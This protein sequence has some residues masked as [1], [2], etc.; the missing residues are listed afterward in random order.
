MSEWDIRK[1]KVVV[2]ICVLAYNHG[3]YIEE[4]LRSL[5][6]QE[7]DFP[8][9]ICIGEDES[10]DET[11]EICQKYASENPDKIRLFLRSRDDV[12][13]INGKATGQY[14][15]MKTLKACRG[16]YIAVCEADDYWSDA[17]KLQVQVSS[18]EQNPDAALCFCNI[19]V[20]Y[21]DG[22]EGHPGYGTLGEQAQS[23]QVG[24]FV[25]PPEKTDILRLA[26]G[27]FIHTPGVL[28][29]NWFLTEPYPEFMF[30]LNLVIG[31]FICAPPVSGTLSS[32]ISSYR[33]I[34]RIRAGCGRT[35]LLRC[36]WP[37]RFVLDAGWCN[38]ASSGTRLCKN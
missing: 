14:N 27:N 38:A 37:Q 26:R 11:R 25:K 9:E 22:T 5:L 30:R 17:R 33:F 29:R 24:M 31:P 16:K 3:T 32:L 4:C 12:I 20:I 18:L 34:G 2:S 19:Q 6:A 21:E 1:D 8:Y 15:C 28:F 7:T 23:R 36:A 13:Y 10:S 35:R